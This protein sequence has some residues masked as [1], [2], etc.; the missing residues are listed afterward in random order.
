MGE[1]W[2]D[3]HREK[4][5]QDRTPHVFSSPERAT[6]AQRYYMIK[7][8]ILATERERE[9]KCYY[10]FTCCKQGATLSAGKLLCSLAR[11]LLP[12]LRWRSDELGKNWRA[13]GSWK[14]EKKTHHS[15]GKVFAA[16]VMRCRTE[17][18]AFPITLIVEMC[19]SDWSKFWG[20]MSWHLL[21][22][23]NG[24]RIFLRTAVT[25]QKTTHANF[26]YTPKHWQ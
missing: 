18:L 7:F 10:R 5:D 21:L 8:F 25:T 20:L 11:N 14:L 13:N 24:H 15:T 19:I 26:S 22:M 3:H 12:L 2:A 4:I 23:L 9:S 17:S 6:P 1:A 16:H